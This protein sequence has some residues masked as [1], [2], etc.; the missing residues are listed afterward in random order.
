[1]RSSGNE[2]VRDQESVDR[3]KQFGSPLFLTIVLRF[4]TATVTKAAFNCSDA[5]KI[6]NVLFFFS[7]PSRS[8]L[9]YRH[10]CLFRRHS[11]LACTRHFLSTRCI[12]HFSSILNKSILSCSHTLSHFPPTSSFSISC[13]F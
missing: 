1:M 6:R 7:S 8:N 4:R 11:N 10:R 5:P 3:H 2:K 9:Y 13:I 12:F